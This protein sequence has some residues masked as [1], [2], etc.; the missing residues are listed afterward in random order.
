MSPKGKFKFLALLIFIFVAGTAA[1]VQT[2]AAGTFQRCTAAVVSPDRTEFSEAVRI[3]LAQTFSSACEIAEDSMVTAALNS[4]D[5][6]NPYNLSEGEVRNLSA[7]A[8][9]D[10]LVLV[11][12]DLQRRTSLEKGDWWEAYTA[13]YL[14]SGRSG[15]LV[16]WFL[17]SAEAPSE[18]G[19]AESL[20]SSLR[21]MSDELRT[22]FQSMLKPSQDERPR[23]G[24]T[25]L[26]SDD[27]SQATRPPAPYKKISPE[28][29]ALARMYGIDGTVEALVD[30]DSDGRVTDVSVTRWAGFG[31]DESVVR[32]V[33]GMN[34]R[35]AEIDGRKIAVRFLVRYNF[36]KLPKE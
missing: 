10:F 30:I 34:W 2:A 14:V 11:R 23:S 29:P 12:G 19:G 1:S 28:Y 16:K 7:A 9:V 24:V 4:Q 18:T 5:L 33:R 25:V 21:A 17:K 20:Y 35:P 31:L 13:V 26:D 27:T 15:R 8:G 22:S 32:T 3:I 6:Q 36:K